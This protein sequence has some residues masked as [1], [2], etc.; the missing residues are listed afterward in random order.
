MLDN[1]AATY[2]YVDTAFG[3]VNRRNHVQRLREVN[4][5]DQ[6][7]ERY[8]THRRG[9]IALAEWVAEHQSVAGYEGEV[10]DASLPFDFDDRNDPA[11][12]LE[13]VRQF[14][15]KLAM[16][17][18]PL[19]ALRFYF[20]GSKGFHLEI[21]HVLFG[22]FE[23]STELHVYERRAAVELMGKILFDKSIYD[24]LR[25]W[26]LPNTLNAKGNHY[27]VRLEL[28]EVLG[29]DMPAILELAEHPRA[30]IPTA[31]DEEWSP[32]EYLVG[33]WARARQLGETAELSEPPTT[34]W[35][36]ARS[37]VVHNAA[38]VAAMAAS[39]PTDLGV[40]RHTDY[41]LPLSG[42]LTRQIGAEPA[43]AMLKEVALASGDLEFI[44]D[45]QRRWSE[46][47]DR[48]CE[49]S[50]AKILGNQPVEGLPTIGKRWPEL[51]DFL[52]AIFIVPSVFPNTGNT[53]NTGSQKG[54]QFSALEMV[55][56]E[57]LELTAYLAEGL[58]PSGG[59]S[60]FGAKPKVGKSV[61]VRNLSMAVAR[62]GVF[63]GRQCHQGTVLY[64]ALEEKRAEVINHFRMMGGTDESLHLHVGAAPASS[65]EGL[66]ALAVAIAMYQPVLVVVDP[67]F[68][69]V[70]VKDSSDYAEL[71][72][73]LEPIIEMAR[74][75]GCHIAL[76][77]HLGKMVREGGDD[78]LGSTAIFGAVDTL[79]LMRRLKDNQRTINSVQRYGT[80]LAETAVPMDEEH[81]TVG[82]GE[83]VTVLK[84]DDAK[85]RVLTTLEK[86]A[87]DY[88]PVTDKIRESAGLERNLCW[89][90]VKELAELGEIQVRGAG[91]PRDPFQ[92]HRRT[93]GS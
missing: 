85:A 76:T 3:G 84:L 66:Q 11:N 12:A 52:S 59:V 63:L 47:I 39:W 90:A 48:L 33:V 89:R 79:L 88:W 77:H 61:M 15:H 35:S 93:L 58:L 13:W 32:N 46:E 60:I 49:G 27:K 45:K 5:D 38:V 55:L 41:L 82:L 31:P 18:V 54:F 68:K 7:A 91:K 62:G 22:G 8:I 34:A 51:A 29:K 25:L 17:D 14:V 2:V 21:P 53:Q 19:D 10:W 6:G 43:A 75:T 37:N 74:T 44:G 92:Y 69:L 40:S 57:P 80:D 65:R 20:S 9:P 23:P 24:K 86:F 26:R 30:A 64:L 87:D 1:V 28:A 81:G 56:S 67:I 50:A 83:L 72:R 71:T 36:E 4:F 73:E 16:E 70:R 78:V 42:F